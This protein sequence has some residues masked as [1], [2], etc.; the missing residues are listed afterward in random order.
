MQD[1][2]RSRSSK[3]TPIGG[4]GKPIEVLAQKL[5][6]AGSCKHESI[7]QA[8]S[9]MVCTVVGIQ[10]ILGVFENHQICVVCVV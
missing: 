4:L 9:R 2:Q 3:F 5:I 10:G 6:A 8:D 7:G 1:T